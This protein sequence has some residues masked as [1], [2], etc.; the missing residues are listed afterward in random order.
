MSIVAVTPT[1]VGKFQK[2]PFSASD[3]ADRLGTIPR[4]SLPALFRE[5]SPSELG[6]VTDRGAFRVL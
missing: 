3:Y 5:L 4:N 6:R 1:L 2:V